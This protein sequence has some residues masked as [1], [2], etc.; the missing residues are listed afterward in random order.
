MKIFKRTLSALLALVMVIGMVPM[1]VAAEESV[2][3]SGDV[4]GNSKLQTNDAKLIRLSLLDPMLMEM[5][6]IIPLM[7]R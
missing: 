1:P 5:V 3:A 2:A 7:H 6:L 4:D